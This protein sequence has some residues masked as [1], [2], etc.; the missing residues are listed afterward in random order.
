[1]R[2]VPVGGR[3]PGSSVIQCGADRNRGGFDVGQ[4]T[5]RLVKARRSQGRKEAERTCEWDRCGLPDQPDRAA[6]SAAEGAGQAPV[7]GWAGAVGPL[8]QQPRPET[9]G[10]PTAETA[11]NGIGL[12][13]RPQQRGPDGAAVR[14]V[15]PGEGAENGIEAAAGSGQRTAKA[16]PARSNGHP[17]IGCHR[18]PL[19]I[20][21]R[22]P[23]AGTG[24]VVQ[25]REDQ[26][27][28]QAVA[29]VHVGREDL[30]AERGG[31]KGAGDCGTR[32]MGATA[33]RNRDL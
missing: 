6:K 7:R 20:R 17:A 11:A 30:G 22:R 1:M 8:R 28:D 12:A 14:R 29:L 23:G 13:E 3:Q 32:Q 25:G 19:R 9:G 2:S 27:L 21:E 33:Q 26:A 18:L 24:E 31:V 4:T 10:G 5:I 15:L 16:G